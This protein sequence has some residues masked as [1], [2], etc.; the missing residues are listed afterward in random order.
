MAAEID[1][2]RLAAARQ[3]LSDW[4][5]ERMLDPS[6]RTTA[7]SYA[8]W[9]VQPYE[10]FLIFSSPGG[11]TNQLYLVGDGIVKPF[12]YAWDTVE[13]AAEAAKAERDGTA[14]PPAPPA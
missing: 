1:E 4:S 13:S 11:Y 3:T 6:M 12:S 5:N 7:D 10:E 8:E 9:Q 14:P 2:A